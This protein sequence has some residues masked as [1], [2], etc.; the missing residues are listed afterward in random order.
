MSNNG[1]DLPRKNRIRDEIN[2]IKDLLSVVER[3]YRKII[4]QMKLQRDIDP[5]STTSTT[6]LTK[7]ERSVFNRYSYH[8]W[9]A[10]ITA[11]LLTFG[12]LN[13]IT[14]LRTRRRT[15]FKLP[16]PP[17]PSY[18]DLDGGSKAK[19]T[20]PI[21]Q[22]QEAPSEPMAVSD[23]TM[24]QLQFM[25]YGAISL[26]VMTFTAANKADQPRYFR[27]LSTLPLQPGRS[28]LCQ[29]MCPEIIQKM[30]VLRQS[31]EPL[32]KGNV[33]ADL[34]KDPETEELERLV[35]LVH[36]CRQR[37]QY[38]ADHKTLD[39]EGPIDVETEIPANYIG[40]NAMDIDWAV[41][42]V[43]DREDDGGTTR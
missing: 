4:N 17:R 16:P 28:V 38:E 12:V 32:P 29:Q 20:K 37:M 33:A 42:L 9:S 3:H 7:T 31:R 43:L 13:G 6:S 1:E 10:G 11:G 23:D 5:K 21:L 2:V 36:N 27:D 26:F 25:V 35:Q 18:K 22:Q 24:S 14:Y 41:D 34:L 30:K 40:V 8:N 19:K 15:N 39:E